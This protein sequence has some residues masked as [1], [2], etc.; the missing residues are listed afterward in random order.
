MNSPPGEGH[1]A[2][3]GRLRTSAGTPPPFSDRPATWIT[4]PKALRG[5]TGAD[6]KRSRLLA[7]ARSN[8][9]HTLAT[10]P[11]SPWKPRFLLRTFRSPQPSGSNAWRSKLDCA[12]EAI[13][14]EAVDAWV[15]QEEKRHRLTLEA[16]AD[17]AA[18][19]LIDHGAVEAWARSLDTEAPLPP[20][21]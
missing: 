6:R 11:R 21:R 8:D 12:P 1:I 15:T 4:H 2:W 18:G 5:M 3:S 20:P 7:R 13:V 16:L 10:E 9:H 14:Q 19:R 17:V